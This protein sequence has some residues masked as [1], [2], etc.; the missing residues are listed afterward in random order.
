MRSPLPWLTAA[1]AIVGANSLSLSPIATVIAADMPAAK[2][3]D[4]VFAGALFGAGSAIS[5]LILAPYA[6]RL[7]LGRALTL[8]VAVLG[9]ALAATGLAQGLW[10]LWVAQAVAGVASGVA[11]PATYGLATAT[12]PE[13]QASRYLGRVLTGWTLSLVFGASL[14]AVLADAFGWRSVYAALAV[15]AAGVVAGLLRADLPNP[16]GGGAAPWGALRV[17]GLFPALAVCLFYM[18]AFYGLYAFLGIHLT[19]DLGAPVWVAGLAP[20][21]YGVGFAASALVDPL[22]DRFGS[23]RVLGPVLAVLA[24]QYAAMAG[25]AWSAAA[26]IAACLSW[27]FINHAGL[28]M[29]VGR[30]AALDPARRGAIL[31]LNSAA[32]Y[33]AAFAGTWGYAVAYPLTGFAGLSVISAVAVVLALLAALPGRRQATV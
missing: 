4:V 30:L 12:A 11:L 20:L 24:V 18:L 25:L 29:I 15:V 14:A 13:G 1:I 33:V 22:I 21:V 7:G 9:L 2:P 27:G 23:E 19:A 28:N 3:T 16:A 5:A 32:T 17:P 31:G 6:D 26:L 8:A 10:V